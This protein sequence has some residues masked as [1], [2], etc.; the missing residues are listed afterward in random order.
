[1]P[2]IFKWLKWH[3]ADAFRGLL[4]AWG[5]FLWFVANYFSLKGLVFSLLSHWKK[6]RL[7]YGR[8]FDPIRFFNVF[9]SN[10]ISRVLGMVIRLFVIAFALI[11]EIL[12][13]LAGLFVVLLWILLP[14]VMILALLY[15]IGSLT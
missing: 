13:F 3:Y 10:M 4:R 12:V 2:I 9:L 5:N 8:G 11:V 14:L 15:S 6:D 7:S 1:M